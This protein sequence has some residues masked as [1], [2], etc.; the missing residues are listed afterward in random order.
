M[1]LLR[2]IPRL[3][4][5]LFLDS[6]WALRAGVLPVALSGGELAVDQQGVGVG[7]L[8]ELHRVVGPLTEIDGFSGE[9]TLRIHNKLCKCFKIICAMAILGASI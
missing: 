3:G 7:G 1:G 9:G 8:I 4:R 2:P 6:G 5:G